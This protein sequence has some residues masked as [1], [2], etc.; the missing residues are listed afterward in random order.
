MAFILTQFLRIQFEGIQI[1]REP[2][3]DLPFS[4]LII[5]KPHWF[6]MKE[7]YINLIYPSNYCLVHY[8]NFIKE[9]IW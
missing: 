3:S 1:E 5:F 8:I 4:F 9:S 2:D 7:T 6:I